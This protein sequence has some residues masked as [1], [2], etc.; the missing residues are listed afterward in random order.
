MKLTSTRSNN[1]RMPGT[2]A[3]NRVAGPHQAGRVG[4]ASSLGASKPA[5]DDD[6]NN[7]KDDDNPRTA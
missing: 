3:K 6:D 4:R 5:D 7:D 1:K 2:L